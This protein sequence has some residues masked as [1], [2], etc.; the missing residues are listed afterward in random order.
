M[1]H[2]PLLFLLCVLEIVLSTDRPIFFNSI[3]PGG[4]QRI[5]LVLPAADANHCNDASIEQ[6]PFATTEQFQIR[7]LPSNNFPVVVCE[8]LVREG[9]TSALLRLADGSNHLLPLLQAS[10]SDG[11]RLGVL[12]DSGCR[13]AC[14]DTKCDMQA[15]EQPSQW[16]LHTIAG[17]LADEK[18]DAVIHVGD[19]QYREA[20]CADPESCARSPHRYDWATFAADFLDP[21]SELLSSTPMVFVRGNHENCQRAGV[22]WLR[23]LSHEAL[24]DQKS[25]FCVE[26]T[27]P[28]KLSIG[29]LEFAVV[30]S[31]AL[32]MP[33]D[34]RSQFQ[35]ADNSAALLKLKEHC[36]ALALGPEPRGSNLIVLVHHPLWGFIPS[37]SGPGMRLYQNSIDSA[38]GPYIFDRHAVI[39]GHLHSLQHIISARGTSQFVL[40][41]GATLLDQFQPLSRPSFTPSVIAQA[42]VIPN[43]FGWSVIESLQGQPVVLK[44]YG[45]GTA[46]LASSTMFP[47]HRLHSELENSPDTIAQE[48]TH[49]DQSREFVWR[50]PHRT[51]TPT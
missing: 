19:Y 43:E 34:L 8:A 26:H 31:A 23:L 12:A 35:V 33:E 9:T 47:T 3:G 18:L 5:R 21:A 29:R 11:V 37:A 28:Y 38:C 7:A 20:R 25:E 13:L 4:A 48:S 16:P 40:G 32:E 10:I 27:N 49:L 42:Q 30:D 41:N 36:Q 44:S 45:L 6:Q 39:S 24:P 22:A 51:P 2:A 17:R 1:E 14:H 46:L 15:C 50:G